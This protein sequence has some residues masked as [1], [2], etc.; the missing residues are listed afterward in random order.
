MRP[1]RN[2]E[3][4]L[5][6]VDDQH[7]LDLRVQIQPAFN[8]LSFMNNRSR[9]VFAAF[10]ISAIVLLQPSAARTQQTNPPQSEKTPS[11]RVL[12]GAYDAAY[13]NGLVFATGNQDSLEQNLFGLRF[14]VFRQGGAIEE[15]SRMFELGP[16]APDDSFARVSW[17]PQFDPKTTITLRW[18]RI[19]KHA[20]VGQLTS[21]ANIRMAIE[22]YRPWNG[23]RDSSAWA[24]FAAQA[25][26]RTVF[27]EQIHNQKNKPPL[28][29]FLFRADRAAVEVASLSEGRATRNLLSRENQSEPVKNNQVPLPGSRS[30]MTFDLSPNAGIGFVTA[31][32][33]EFD[34]MQNEVEKLLGQP[35]GE[36]LDKAERQYE[37]IKTMSGGALGDGVEAIN[38][39]TMWNRFYWPEQRNEYVAMHRYSRQGLRGDA[40][41]WDS[42]LTA[43][44]TALTNEASSTATL[45]M[46]LAVQ[47]SDGRIPMR[48]YMQTEPVAEPPVLAGRTMP[49]LGALCALKVYLATQ[50]LAFLAWAYPRLQQWNDWW[51]SNRGD[52]KK[53]RDGNMDGLLEWGFDEEQEYGAMG[54]RTLTVADKQRLAY[55]EAGQTS[56]DAKYNEQSHT[57][58]I[59]S[60]ALNSLYAL[61]TELLMSISRE[62]GLTT[63]A[64]RWQLRY[65]EIKRLVNEKLWS[66]EDGLYFDKHWSGK[67]S[68]R[69]SLENFYPLIAGIPDETRARRMLTALHDYQKSEQAVAGDPAQAAMSYLLYVGL[70][71]YGFYDEAAEL[72]RQCALS[73]RAASTRTGEKTGKLAELFGGKTEPADK[74]LTPQQ[75]SFPGLLYLPGIEE[76]IST[77]PWSGLTIGNL[78]VAE[79]SR[80][81]RI[82]IGEASLDVII[83]PKRTVIRRNGSIEIEFEAPVR[84][85][86]YR[87][88]DRALGF[89]VE[90][91]ET[92]RALVPASEGRKVTVS[93]NDKILGSTSPGAAASFKVK[94]GISKV[95]IVH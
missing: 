40:L 10:L 26:R 81:E 13:V 67:F 80:V 92:V 3:D 57:L 75:L 28:S 71:R 69:I 20:L 43:V 46:L 63:E 66:E 73:A 52:G 54:A 47:T 50:D 56:G 53:W 49:P 55:A 8:L 62:I 44:L 15:S 77:D 7:K 76:I 89:M 72:A 90:A 35:I 4:G 34:S 16:H 23:D 24:A 94:D 78:S 39:L 84:L 22:A 59:S 27:G 68:S 91:K 25:D 31:V 86:G 17:Q 33:N 74:P 21:S 36:L 41:G 12:I 32:G 19:G 61:D 79:E 93:V 65:D 5:Q 70:R 88:N 58:E 64:D 83:G 85:R 14:L 87:G 9:S 18:S 38:R 6:A 11:E 48:R 29:R 1:R 30:V 82:K 45:R 51:H 42:M 60:V 37:A 95:L 2:D